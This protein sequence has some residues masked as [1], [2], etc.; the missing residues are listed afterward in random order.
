M[1]IK[2]IIYLFLKFSIL[3]T[4]WLCVSKYSNC[5]IWICWCVVI[6][7]LSYIC[8]MSSLSLSLSLTCPFDFN[9]YFKSLIHPTLSVAYFR[10]HILNKI[11]RI[12]MAQQWYVAFVWISL[13]TGWM[14]VISS[15]STPL[16]IMLSILVHSSVQWL[17][18][19]NQEGL[20][21][22]LNSS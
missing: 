2:K 1:I 4:F 5:S 16:I 14:S 9:G 21:W 20:I 8:V 6:A 3:V 22:T 17:I 12:W 18:A 10:M 19:K 13:I 11:L 7:L 15:E